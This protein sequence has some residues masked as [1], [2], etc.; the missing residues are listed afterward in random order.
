MVSTNCVPTENE[1][2]GEADRNSIAEDDPMDVYPA[3]ELKPFW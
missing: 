3:T 1:A 2:T